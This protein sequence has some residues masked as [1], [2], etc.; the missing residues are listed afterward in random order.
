MISPYLAGKDL[1]R[2]FSKEFRNVQRRMV[3][4]ERRSETASQ[5]A[6]NKFKEF[7]KSLP[8]DWRFATDEDLRKYFSDL[9][10]ISNLKSATVKGAVRTKARF[11]PIERE[12]E[13]VSPLLKEKFWASYQK[14]VEENILLEKY[15]YEIMDAVKTAVVN[16]AQEPDEILRVINELYHTA[17]LEGEGNEKATDKLFIQYLS[18]FS[19][20]DI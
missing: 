17:T 11:G 18:E 6:V 13:F 5:I 10:Y 14:L 16:Q 20:W 15:K 2:E 8:S 3:N 1:R 12:L 9:R 19:K 7:R 4:I